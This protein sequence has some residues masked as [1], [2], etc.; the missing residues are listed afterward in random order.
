MSSKYFAFI[1]R[2]YCR[3][4]RAESVNFENLTFL[5][6]IYFPSSFKVKF[7]TVDADDRGI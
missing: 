7:F 1:L 2:I 5:K 4:Q 6:T 3:F